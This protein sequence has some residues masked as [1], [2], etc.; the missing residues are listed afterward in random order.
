MD[1]KKSAIVLNG[2]I[3][4]FMTGYWVSALIVIYFLHGYQ[5]KYPGLA[6]QLNAIER[7]FL[8]YRRTMLFLG[9]DIH[10]HR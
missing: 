6:S 10:Y 7:F 5:V 4:D 2:F 3:H 8:P 1:L 9:T